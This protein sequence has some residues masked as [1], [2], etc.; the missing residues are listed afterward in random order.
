VRAA[1]STGAEIRR[2][3]PA[4]AILVADDR[5]TGVRLVSGETLSAPLVLSSLDAQTTLCLTGAEHFDAEAVRRI[6][7]VR[8]KGMTAKINLA[9][10]GLPAFSGV[11]RAQLAGRLVLAPSSQALEAAFNSAKYGELPARPALE[12]LVPSLTDPGLVDGRGGDGPGHVMS[13]VVQYAP[14]HLKGGWSD[15]ARD[16]L[17]NSVLD[18][19]EGFAPGL[20]RLV[21]ARDVLTP[22][23]IE[24][25]TGATGGHWHHGELA[26]DQMLTLRPVNGLAR[27]AMP[28]GGLHLCGAAAHPGGDVVGAAGHNAARQAM[29]GGQAA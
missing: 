12:I 19:L 27:Y 4:A 8:S 17:G 21:L 7:Q 22:A 28:V 15:A 6:R 23:D 1:E 13:I 25:E 26:I 10:S 3:A 14:Y 5:V 2:Q 9:L 20:R 16:T 18:L 24:R 29:K 11:D